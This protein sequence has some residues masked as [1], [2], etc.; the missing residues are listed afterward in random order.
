M[1]IKRL[2]LAVVLV[3][4]AVRAEAQMAQ[5]WGVVGLGAADNQFQ[6]FSRTFAA[7]GGGEV[8]VADR[9]GLGAD[10]GLAAGGGDVWL[11]FS[12]NGT[13]YIPRARRT[14]AI[15]PYVSGGFTW[16]NWLTETGHEA[17]YNVAAGMI[18][19]R[20]G[21]Q[22]LRVELRDVIRP[23]E[24][25]AIRGVTTDLSPTRHWWSV[26]IGVALR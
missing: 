21:R 13:Y 12:L 8:L 22:G 7:T 26:N 3:L 1:I 10:V 15:V 24:S 11:P 19:W 23:G 25:F 4:A 2:E 17:D 9:I 5:G 6:T 14:T 18:L 20:T 16:L